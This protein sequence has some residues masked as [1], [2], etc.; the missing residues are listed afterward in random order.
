MDPHVP[1]S[2]FKLWLRELVDPLVPSEVYN[3]CIAFAA[4]CNC[5]Q[6]LL[7]IRTTLPQSCARTRFTCGTRYPN[8]SADPLHCRDRY[9]NHCNERRSGGT[10]EPLS[11]IRHGVR[12]R[13]LLLTTVMHT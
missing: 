2:L 12:R 1:A 7:L 6:F 9:P 5:S 3:N 8:G 10:G 11:A 4:S 13:C